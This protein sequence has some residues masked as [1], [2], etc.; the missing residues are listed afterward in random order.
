[1]LWWDA[2]SF[3]VLCPH[4]EGI[5]R[6]STNLN[7]PKSRAPHCE[8]YK[9]YVCSFP[10]NDQGQVAYEIDKRRARFV[11][12]CA[13]RG[14][15]TGEMD[16]M[17]EMD[18]LAYEFAAKAN[19]TMS[20]A[21]D[22]ITDR[23]IYDDAHEIITIGLEGSE[24]VKVKRILSAIGDCITGKTNTVQKYLE[25]SVDASTFLHGRDYNADTTLILAAAEETSTMVSLLLKHGAKVNAVNKNGRSALMEAIL[26]GRLNKV[27]LLIE[28]GADRNLCLANNF[29]QPTQKKPT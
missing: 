25:S 13:S 29:A 10:I 8:S 9:H 21:E 2:H 26:W 5:H 1:M 7:R 27:K 22:E 23:N 15:A 24:P 11:N 16:E 6:H 4:C 20:E 19:V 17:D 3:H 12:I 28:H 18:S 14:M